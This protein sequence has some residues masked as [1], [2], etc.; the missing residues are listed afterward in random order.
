MNVVIMGSDSQFVWQ[1]IELT[2]KEQLNCIFK[3]FHEY[4]WKKTLITAAQNKRNEISSHWLQNA[5]D[6]S[7]NEFKLLI[8]RQNENS[9]NHMCADRI[10]Y[11]SE[12]MRDK[13][14]TISV[15]ACRLRSFHVRFEVF[16]AVTMKN[17]V[18]W[19]VTPCGPCKNRRFVGT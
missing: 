13:F 8:F 11:C 18:F 15:R 10:N 17:G 14:T 6:L 5:W 9:G 1:W 3:G 19:D 16:T 2:L 4:D 7:W 12:P